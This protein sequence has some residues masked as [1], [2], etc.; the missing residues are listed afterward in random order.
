MS[1]GPGR[2]E[3]VRRKADHPS[4]PVWSLAVTGAGCRVLVL[5][6]G[7]SEYPYTPVRTGP[8][9]SV[10]SLGV[11]QGTHGGPHSGTRDSLGVRFGTGT[12]TGTLSAVAAT[13]YRLLNRDRGTPVRR[14]PVGA[15]MCRL[16]ATSGGSEGLRVRTGSV[17][18]PVSVTVRTQEPRGTSPSSPQTGVHRRDGVRTFRP[19]LGPDPGRTWVRVTDGHGS[20]SA[21]TRR[22]PPGTRR[23]P[24]STTGGGVV[25][26]WETP[27]TA[28][29]TLFTPAVSGRC[30]E[31][32]L[33]V[34]STSDPL[35]G[36]SL[37]TVHQYVSTGTALR[38]V[39]EVRQSVCGAPGGIGT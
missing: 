33:A 36:R 37:R 19:Q 24:E 11:C 18:R 35:T 26:P 28:G 4:C 2:V 22:T 6:P 13:G 25:L 1:P 23:F 5:R 32:R 15:G 31:G 30:Q 21:V 3:T 34:R 7:H 14:G 8:P 38:G 12:G 29:G 20:P 39:V 16:R 17:S 10:S 27:F 9:G